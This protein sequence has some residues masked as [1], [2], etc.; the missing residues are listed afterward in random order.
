MNE[1]QKKE[2]IKFFLENKVKIHLELSDKTFFNGILLKQLKEKV[3]ILDEIKIGET[4]IFLDDIEVIEQ[5]REV[6]K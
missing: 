4:F 2:R 1:E 6:Q 5:F 3:W